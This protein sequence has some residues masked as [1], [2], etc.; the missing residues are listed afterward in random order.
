MNSQD[1]ITKV[2]FGLQNLLHYK[3]TK[4]GDSALNP[5]K[6]FSKHDADSGILIRLDDKMSRIMNSE[7]GLRKNDVAD[8]LGYLTL[9]CVEKE[10]WDFEEMMD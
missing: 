5:V 9:Y 7:E 6:I 2:L 4:Y 1:K 3:N 10:W 8:I